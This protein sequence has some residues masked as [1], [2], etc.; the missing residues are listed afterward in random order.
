MELIEIRKAE[1]EQIPIAKNTCYMLHSQ[2][3]YPGLIFKVAGKLFFDTEEWVAMCK[4]A[5][6]ANS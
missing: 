5:T 4:A 2:G 1:P 3:R 6:K